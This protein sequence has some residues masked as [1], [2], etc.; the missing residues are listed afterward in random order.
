MNHNLC[1][2]QRLPMI[3]KC[4]P[5]PPTL[6]FSFIDMMEQGLT[7]NKQFLLTRQSLG[8]FRG[9]KI[10]SILPLQEK[11]NISHMFIRTL[12]AL[13]KRFF[14]MGNSISSM[15]RNF[16]TFL[17]VMIKSCQLLQQQMELTFTLILKKAEQSW[18]KPSMKGTLS[19][20]IKLA[21]TEHTLSLVIP[22]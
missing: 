15:E 16:D 12:E 21:T 6:M 5:L 2:Q 11:G 1:R 19:S 10:I 8:E 20:P 9:Q 13:T 18:N 4:Q 17:S 14:R 7:N 22:V 3:T